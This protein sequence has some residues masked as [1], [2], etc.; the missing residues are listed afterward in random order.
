MAF[1]SSISPFLEK[2]RPNPFLGL[3]FSKLKASAFHER[4]RPPCITFAVTPRSRAAAMTS[5]RRTEA[6]CGGMENTLN[7]RDGDLRRDVQSQRVPHLDGQGQHQLLTG[8]IQDDKSAKQHQGRSH[9]PAACNLPF[10]AG[11]LQP[12][13][14]RFLG[15]ALSAAVHRLSNHPLK[16]GKQVVVELE[17]VLGQQLGQEVKRDAQSGK[18]DQALERQAD[19]QDVYLGCGTAQYPENDVTD[20]RDREY[21]SCDLYPGHEHLRGESDQILD[22]RCMQ[23]YTLHREIVETVVHCQEEQ[24]WPLIRRKSKTPR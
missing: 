13:R 4:A 14:G 22:E 6:D 8:V 15:P 9:L 12:S 19:D 11:F 17:V 7:E 2:M 1:I 21:R 3:S 23:G 18:S 5:P 16:Q 10:L 24:W 20:D